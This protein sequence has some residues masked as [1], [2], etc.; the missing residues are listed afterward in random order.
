MAVYLRICFSLGLLL[1]LAA[2][3]EEKR[4][5]SPKARPPVP[6][7]AAAA[8]TRTVPVQLEAIGNVEP[9]TTV[10]VKSM[11]SGEVVKVHFK[12]GQD[13][14]KGQLLFTIDPRQAQAALKQA[15]S[16]ITRT[17]AQLAKAR[18]DADRYERL[19]RDGI[20]TQDQFET[21]RTQAD[22][23]AADVAAQE[24]LIQNLKVQ[25][26][27]CTIRSPLSGRTGNLMI[28]A[29]NVVKANDT[30]SL[31]T[32][33]QI[34]PISVTFTLPE[35][36]LPRIRPQLAAGRLMAEATPSGDAGKPESGRVTF[37]D[38]AVDTATGT[39][40]LKATFANAGRRLWPGQFAT[41]RLTLS[42]LAGA[43][44]VPSQAVQTGQQGQYLFVIRADN[45]AE[46]R[47]VKTGVT[48]NGS[49]VIEQ[50]VRPGERVVVDGQM[51]LSPGAPV[52]TREPARPEPITKNRGT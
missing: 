36:E 52:V 2:C 26:S 42:T 48:Y 19:V 46:L 10:S 34:T 47:P 11:V 29:G 25:L 38:N 8:T 16:A 33:N 21:Y 24:A 6:I 32:I 7:L 9:L 4:Q 3:G 1:I 40:R 12:E 15:E 45:T 49:T 27:Y 18:T 41:V 35:K 13:V 28:N 5:E 31:V 22:A 23:L 30:V 43:T 17:K 50:G 51:R 37:L 14:L 20:V 44:V 39:I